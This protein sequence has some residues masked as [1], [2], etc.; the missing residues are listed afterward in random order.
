MSRHWILYIG[1]FC[2]VFVHFSKR[3]TFFFYDY[4]TGSYYLFLLFGDLVFLVLFFVMMYRI[5]LKVTRATALFFLISALLIIYS[6]FQ[7][8]LLTT[9]IS[10]RNSYLWFGATILVLLGS[11]VDGSEKIDMHMFLFIPAGLVLAYGL[12]QNYLDYQFEIAWFANSETSLVIEGVRNFGSA[13]KIF[14]F[15]SGPADF[16]YFGLFVAIIGWKGGNKILVIIGFLIL[17]YSGTRSVIYAVPIWIL[18][19]VV[20]KRYAITAFWMGVFSAMLLMATNSALL[21]TYFY[22]LTNSRFSFATL[23]PRIEI[24]S[25]FNF[26]NLLIGGGLAYNIARAGSGFSVGALDSEVLYFISELGL[27]IYL[28]V[29]IIFSRFLFFGQSIN[30][31]S[32]V[33]SFVAIILVSTLAQLPFHMRLVNFLVI[34]LVYISSHDK[35]IYL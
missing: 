19:T 21:I 17:F 8:G 4:Q 12:I 22:N 14:S 33:V 32:A 1:I 23:A 2:E 18:L 28:C 3:A 13:N 9:I 26:E 16:A 7:N 6:V 25:S 29:M 34:Y 11:R 27:A 20:F 30:P 10:L 15:F 35:K 5:Q 31:N 24:W